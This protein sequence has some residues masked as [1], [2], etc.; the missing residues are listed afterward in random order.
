[1]G[2]TFVEEF[3]CNYCGKPVAPDD[4]WIG[5]LETRRHGS[6]GRGS[7]APKLAFHPT[8][9]GAL[10]KGAEKVSRPRKATVRASLPK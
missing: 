5:T 4:V 6:K 1:M 8:C 7:Q 9:A 10:T 2:V 3:V